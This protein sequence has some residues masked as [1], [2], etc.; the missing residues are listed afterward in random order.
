M[1]IIGVE[2]DMRVLNTKKKGIAIEDHRWV[3]TKT[4]IGLRH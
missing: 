4:I 3:P 1:D 2:I